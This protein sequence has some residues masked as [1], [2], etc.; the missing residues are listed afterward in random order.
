LIRSLRTFPPFLPPRSALLRNQGPG[1]N[2]F[3]SYTPERAYIEP[4]LPPW[5]PSVGRPP[6]ARESACA[7]PMLQGRKRVIGA[8]P[9]RTTRSERAFRTKSG[10]PSSKTS[11]VGGWVLA[12]RECLP[13]VSTRFCGLSCLPGAR[14][15][16]LLQPIRFICFSLA[17][18]G[19][20]L[21]PRGR[22]G[23]SRRARS[24]TLRGRTHSRRW[25][26]PWFGVGEVVLLAR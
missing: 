11:R 23:C 4:R 19:A 9:H 13:G 5:S 24:P 26:R 20:G 21:L 10:R 15:I 17:Q 12:V 8:S 7:F 2:C 18:E 3:P 14:S 16:K 22:G 25:H 6:G 1:A